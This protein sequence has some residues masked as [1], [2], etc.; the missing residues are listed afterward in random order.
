MNK[1]FTFYLFFIWAYS[2]HAQ[3]IYF[4][5]QY[6]MF[7]DLPSVGFK[8]ITMPD[9]YA[10]TTLEGSNSNPQGG[11]M[12]I[13]DK[14]GEIIHTKQ[15][16]PYTNIING[17]VYHPEDSTFNIWGDYF[18]G[19]GQNLY[20]PYIMKTNWWGDTIWVKE[21]NIPAFNFCRIALELPDGGFILA[22]STS[23]P[24]PSVVGILRIDKD[25]NKLWHKVM[26]YPPFE[27]YDTYGLTLKNDSTFIVGFNATRGRIDTL[28]SPYDAY[29]LI[30]MNLEGSVIKEK[31]HYTPYWG[32]SS[33]TGWLQHLGTDKFAFIN[34]TVSLDQN[35][36]Q[37]VNAIDT[38]YNLLWQ[39][40]T[41]DYGFASYIP[42]F[43]TNLKGNVVGGGSIATPT[44][45]YPYLFE[46]DGAGTLLWKR[47]VKPPIFGQDYLGS[48]TI[49][50]IRPTDDGGYI[51]AGKINLLDN[52]FKA[53]LLKLDSLGCAE[54]GC[55]TDMFS[56]VD[57]QE[58]LQQTV[59]M[60]EL[61]LLPNPAHHNVTLSTESG[62]L[63]QVIIT[64]IRGRL[65]FSQ[66]A[67]GAQIII[68]TEDWPSGVYLVKAFD[69]KGRFM[70]SK[71]L[72]V[73]H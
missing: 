4:S 19:A 33:W 26:T 57:L 18:I 13:T 27:G 52:S 73:Q 46:M 11:V 65:A 22:L 12:V 5:K 72:V 69:E 32:N 15:F 25:G 17:L 39:R 20:R 50:S 64:D 59:S 71:K 37:W 51:M 58:A 68:A 36:L 31:L 14:N 30:E 47:I 10:F 16:L 43:D 40:Y 41:S 7:P 63:S 38:N 8:V 2:L 34:R 6:T 56:T 44:G 21:F 35:G 49:E 70:R 66:L 3:S 28:D 60:A 55:Q 54:P 53:W 23:T 45:L 62:T 1:I 24:A 67:A 29:G 9:G 61:S 42:A 48:T